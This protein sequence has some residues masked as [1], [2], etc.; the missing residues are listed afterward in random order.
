MKVSKLDYM[1]LKRITDIEGLEK[2]KK[3]GKFYLFLD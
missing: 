1:R 2:E 3:S